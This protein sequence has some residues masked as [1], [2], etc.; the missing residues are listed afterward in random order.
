MKEDRIAI[1]PHF[2]C[3]HVA[4]VKPLKF[5]IF[6]FRKYPRCSRHKTPL[7]FIEEFVGNFLHAV[8]ACL[9]DMQH[10][11]PEDLMNLIKTR[12]QEERKTFLNG[13]LYCM[14]LGRGARIVPNYL[15]G[16]S[17]AYMKLLSKKQRKALEGEKRE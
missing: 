11:I 14:S 9:F 3:S 6:G 17:R 8:N 7:V 10:C 13:W 2:G 1:C 4:K 5:G 16:L 12:P 15:N